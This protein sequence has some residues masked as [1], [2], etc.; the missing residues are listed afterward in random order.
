MQDPYLKVSLMYKR[1]I[2]EYEKYGKLVVGY[3]FDG[4]VHDF[5]KEGHEYPRV[6]QLLRDL[7]EIGCKLICWTAYGDLAYVE[8]YLKD[9]DIPCDGINEG[10]I[11][12]P[13]ESRKPFF[14]ALLDDRAGMLE[15]FVGLKKVIEHV[16]LKKEENEN[17]PFISNGLL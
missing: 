13:W 4:T 9:N 5:H 2:D 14:S 15:V 17:Q 12:L 10:G 6:I 3:D 1:L 16:K 7:K 8:K 11:P